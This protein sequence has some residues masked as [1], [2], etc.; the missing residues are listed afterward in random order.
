VDFEAV[1]EK[2]MCIT[3]VPG[4]VGPMTIVMM[5]RNVLDAYSAQV[6]QPK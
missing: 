2:A 5:L 6:S 1:D 3:P 4:G